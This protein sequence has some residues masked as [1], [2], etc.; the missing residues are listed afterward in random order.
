MD[1]KLRVIIV[2]DEYLVR[3]LI[4]MKA[5]WDELGMEVVGEASTADEAL[6]MLDSLLPDIVF[7]DI[8]MPGMNGI[9]LSKII[10][11]RYPKIKV[12]IITGYNEF[13]YARN[14]I[15]LGVSDF[16]LKPINSQELMDSLKKVRNEIV[17]ERRMDS[18][19]RF[20]KAQI[21]DKYKCDDES[22]IAQIIRYINDHLEDKNLS[23][24]EIADEFFISK[25]YL[26]KLFKE[27]T[28]YTVG[29]YITK[30]RMEHAKILLAETTLKGYQVGQKIG[31]DDPHYFSILFK[32]Y[33]G[34]TVSE[35]RKNF[36]KK[37]K[38]YRLKVQ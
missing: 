2:D 20:L 7:T 11:E 21:L 18:E 22:L 15:K 26:S 33:T 38:N 28:S 25:E 30:L 27:A 3:N 36:S 14:C 8:C 1:E 24:S 31:I 37:R 34:Q 23:L 4:K 5:R 35:F 32:K 12:L 9:E 6:E 10:L 16:I 19:Y 17:E 13:E 29:E